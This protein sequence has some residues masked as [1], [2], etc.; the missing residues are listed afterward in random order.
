MPDAFLSRQLLCFV[1]DEQPTVDEF[2]RRFGGPGGQGLHVLRKH[3]VIVVDGDRV[4]LSRR[5]LSPDGQRFVCGIQ[6][7]HLDEEVSKPQ[8][9]IV[10]ATSARKVPPRRVPIIGING[11]FLQR[12]SQMRV[13]KTLSS[14]PLLAF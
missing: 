10:K 13:P 1:R 7:I 14:R 2:T 11:R 6:V 4:R 3:G 12:F 9:W 5:H 8:K